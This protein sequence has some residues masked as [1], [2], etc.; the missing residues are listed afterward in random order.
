MAE[1][2]AVVGAVA[3]ALQF[4]EVG[5]KIIARG[6]SLIKHSRENPEC[7]ERAHSQIRH[8]LY[9]AKLTAENGTAPQD[10]IPFGTSQTPNEEFPLSG[11]SEHGVSASMPARMEEIWTDCTE[12]AK[13]LDS[14]LR[15]MTQ[16]VEGKS[17]FGIW[18]RLRRLER[19]ERI[20]RALNELERSKSMLNLSF[21]HESGRQ[22]NRLHRDVS[23]M[24]DDIIKF[25]KHAFCGFR[26]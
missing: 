20:D 3:G 7:I 9:L 8:L 13:V 15:S 16:E 2:V 24:H 19:L 10:M 5:Y 12:Q 22:I 4:A 18:R 21:V 14:I 1:A 11:N 25:G 23:F 26:L 17:I 6:S